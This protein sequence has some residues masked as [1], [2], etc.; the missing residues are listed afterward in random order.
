MKAS[1]TS[2]RLLAALLAVSLSAPALAGGKGSDSKA[3]CALPG[4]NISPDNHPDDGM[5]LGSIIEHEKIT[6]DYTRT[7]EPRL[8]LEWGSSEEITN[9][10]ETNKKKLVFGDQSKGYQVVD[11]KERGIGLGINGTW[12]FPNSTFLNNAVWV[13]VGL[14][15]VTGRNSMAVRW[16][17]NMNAVE[18]RA[19]VPSLAEAQAA[20]ARML[21]GDALTYNTYGGIV[22]W[23]GFGASVIGI[24][25][26]AMARGDF[27][28]YMEKLDADLVYVKVSDSNVE[29]LALQ[30]GALLSKV[31]TAMY[32][33]YGKAF[34]FALNMKDP[35]AQRA[36][37]DLV[38]GNIAPV[39]KLA[40][41]TDSSSVRF[42][43]ESQRERHGNTQYV[44]YFGIPFLLKMSWSRDRYFE[45]ARSK[46]YECGRVLSATYG[47][48]YTEKYFKLRPYSK[49]TSKAFYGTAYALKDQDAKNVA[50]G[51][52]GHMT[53]TYQNNDGTVRALRHAME[54]MGEDT[55][56]GDL[57]MLDMP[58]KSDRFGNVKLQL[59][60]HFSARTTQNIVRRAGSGLAGS[61]KAISGKLL[62]GA[63]PSLFSC[64][65]EGSLES[66]S[67]RDLVASKTERGA[68][69]MADAALDLAR[70]LRTG[71]ERKATQA[72]AR[73]GEAMLTN[74]FTFKAGLMLAGD[75]MKVDYV[76][77]GS[78]FSTYTATFRTSGWTGNL[79]RE[80]R[81]PL[82]AP[83]RGAREGT[84]AEDAFGRVVG[85]EE[86]DQLDE[87][88]VL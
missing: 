13:S 5:G 48:Y 75:N 78:D 3:A 33:K 63:S 45:A 21:P 50:R 60:G 10:A 25:T 27:Q 55:G 39:Q 6:G 36:Y 85:G 15:P 51:F 26:A 31:S 14:L 35:I 11:F 84:P 41:R 57:L 53:Y 83:R 88:V 72:Y 30:A 80:S 44:K 28:V 52:F 58:E 47:A 59:R 19:A 76:V 64:A 79:V 81:E 77:S 37:R 54:R 71:N 67:C 46:S 24:Q 62:A 70:A 22:F 66:G 32:S 38:R 34:G 17:P 69:K 2:T 23:A 1:L 61:L 12:E 68:E 16:F 8:Y 73:F 43:D 20:M 7:I 9:L 87:I 82:V 42:W 40:M 65:E 29:S 74:A 86:A 18:N 56:L 4:A 49:T